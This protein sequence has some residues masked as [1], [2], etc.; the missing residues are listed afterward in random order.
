MYF[1][2][3]FHF[4]VCFNLLC[5]LSIQNEKNKKT[6]NGR[7][8]WEWSLSPPQW[9]EED[10]KSLDL[11]TTTFSLAD[12]T[13][14]LNVNKAFVSGLF[15]YFESNILPPVHFPDEKVE[16]HNDLGKNLQDNALYHLQQEEITSPSSLSCKTNAVHCPSMYL[17]PGNKD[18]PK[19]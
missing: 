15:N 11:G 18:L 6:F 12:L 13:K 17:K 9:I 3:V 2:K 8:T 16:D 4:A 1:F 10:E 19:F 5:S 14:Y 7:T